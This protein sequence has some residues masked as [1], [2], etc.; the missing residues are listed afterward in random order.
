[1]IFESAQQMAVEMSAPSLFDA[2]A[3]KLRRCG[4]QSLTTMDTSA[5]RTLVA[6]VKALPGTWRPV[7]VSAWSVSVGSVKKLLEMGCP[8]SGTRML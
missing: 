4:V 7:S 6:S 3:R 8:S 5:S 2:R 1:M